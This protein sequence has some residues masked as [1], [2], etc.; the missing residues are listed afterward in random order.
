MLFRSMRLNAEIHKAS[1]APDMKERFD[2]LG[3]IM[4]LSTPE[5]VDAAI[6]RDLARAAKL[7]KDAAIPVE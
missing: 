1:N 3:F 2:Q 4:T 5:E 6:K 7:V